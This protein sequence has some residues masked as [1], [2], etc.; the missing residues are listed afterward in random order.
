MILAFDGK[1]IEDMRVL[2]RVV[3]ETAIDAVVD[4]EIWRDGRT[5]TIQVRVG[6]LT[7]VAVAALA[8][9]Q[10]NGLQDST[11]SLGMSL[12][13]VTPELREQYGLTLDADGV[14]VT[15]VQAATDAAARRIQPGD[16]ILEVGQE[17]VRS[18]ADIVRLVQAAREE[19]RSSVLIFLQERDGDLR[20][21]ALSLE[22]G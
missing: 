17:A 4:V 7:D 11:N 9:A 10:P 1:D 12:A 3:A 16:V 6:E 14:L 13:A 18:P 19:N 20:F 22:Q 8:G 21:V 15:G 2:T 5:Q